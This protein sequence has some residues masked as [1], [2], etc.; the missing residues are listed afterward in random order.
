M[1]IHGKSRIS[2]EET[3]N[4]HTRTSFF[5]LLIFIDGGCRCLQPL[6]LILKYRVFFS[7]ACVLH[8]F[9][10]APTA[11][12]LFSL[13]KKIKT[14]IRTSSFCSLLTLMC[15]SFLFFVFFLFG[16]FIHSF[17]LQTLTFRTK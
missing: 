11:S 7:V 9:S 6:S 8:L 17:T 4:T 14:I 15:I 1:R 5:Q 3:E 10:I 16:S 13:S 12:F 2:F